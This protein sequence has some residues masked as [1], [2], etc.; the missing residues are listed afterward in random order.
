MH[1]AAR[2]LRTARAVRKV[3]I[4]VCVIAV[5]LSACSGAG[6]VEDGGRASAPADAAVPTGDTGILDAG[7]SRDTGVR[8]ALVLDAT[9]GRFD[10]GPF[11]AGQPIVDPLGPAPE[12]TIVESGIG[13]TEGPTWVPELNGFIYNLTDRREPDSHRLWR[14]GESATTE[15]F[16]VRG[17]NHGAIYSHGWIFLTNREPG[18]IGRV[19]PVANPTEEIVIEARIPRGQELG[20]PND[21]DRFSDGSLF[22]SDWGGGNVPPNHVGFGLYRLHEDGRFE[23]IDRGLRNPNGVAFSADCRTLYVADQPRIYRYDVAANGSLSQRRVHLDSRPGVNG[24]AV[25]VR[26]NLYTTGNQRMVVFDALG[27]QIATLD[28]PGRQRPVNL[29]FGGS[30]Q[31]RLFITTSDGVIATRTRI[32][33]AECNGLGTRP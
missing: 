8:D 14:P 10:A 28:P 33:G 9:P 27:N 24:I 2:A 1:V 13:W 16:R 18:R 32:A 6:R 26:G 22:F 19:R 12:V 23:V 31:R 25:D 20:L 3:G 11:D 7:R 21:L 29:S 30:D 15:W 17:S 5:T 4:T